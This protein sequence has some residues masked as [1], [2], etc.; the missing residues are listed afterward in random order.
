M[1]LRSFQVPRSP[2]TPNPELRPNAERRTLNFWPAFSNSGSTGNLSTVRI[3][4]DVIL[5]SAF[6]IQQSAS[7]AFSEQL[8]A[9]DGPMRSC[10][11]WA[12]GSRVIASDAE[13]WTLTAETCQIVPVG[14]CLVSR[15][16]RSPSFNVQRLS[17]VQGHWSGIRAGHRTLDY[18]RALD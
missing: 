16:L 15:Q 9:L 7:E 10:V 6:S 4:R 18:G 11:N 3:K 14:P 5:H 8:S 1:V 2:S 13:D 17:V 12:M